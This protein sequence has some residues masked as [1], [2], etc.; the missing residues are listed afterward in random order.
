M[1]EQS[2]PNDEAILSDR[3]R[4]L[5]KLY[6]NSVLSATAISLISD[7][8]LKLKKVNLDEDIQAIVNSIV[9]DESDTSLAVLLDEALTPLN[10]S[11]TKDILKPA[12][13]WI[14]CRLSGKSI[15]ECNNECGIDWIPPLE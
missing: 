8:S 14:S 3:D 11:V 13:C 2:R 1:S 9:E 7:K 10:D 12:R 5:L 4:K 6:V 15:S